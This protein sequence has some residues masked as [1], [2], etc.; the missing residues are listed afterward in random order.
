MG[1]GR[2]DVPLFK[3]MG[4]Q[5]G[6]HYPNLC[7]ECARRDMLTDIF[8]RLGTKITDPHDELI[9]ET[10]YHEET[11]NVIADIPGQV[12]VRPV[13]NV[14]QSKFMCMLLIAREEVMQIN[15]R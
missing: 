1:C 6:R 12:I 3:R 11:G 4:F 10:A 14:R 2:Q 9:P 7:V 13:E 5:G 15:D 8:A